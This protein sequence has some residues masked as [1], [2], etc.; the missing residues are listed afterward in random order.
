MAEAQTIIN[1]SLLN[2]KS[3]YILKQIF[4]NLQKKILLNFI[5]YNKILQKRLNKDINDYKIEYSKIEL[6]I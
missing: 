1:I 2:I 6:E 4:N 3:N 5:R